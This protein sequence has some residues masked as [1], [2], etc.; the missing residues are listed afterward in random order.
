MSELL[1]M[2]SSE[3]FLPRRQLPFPQEPDSGMPWQPLLTLS[4]FAHPQQGGAQISLAEVCRSGERSTRWYN[5]LSYKY[6]KKQSREPKPVGARAPTPG[7]ESTVSWA[8]GLP[9]PP[10]CAAPGW[11][12]GKASPRTGDGWASEVEETRTRG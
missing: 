2:I 7:P 6:L 11:M 10:A 9:H 3:P 8:T 12:E 5:L 1:K 4:L